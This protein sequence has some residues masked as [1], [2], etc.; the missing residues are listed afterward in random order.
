MGS[1]LNNICMYV[2]MYMLRIFNNHLCNS[3][4]WSCLFFQITQLFPGIH[5][6]MTFINFIIRYKWVFIS[7]QK[8]LFAG[9]LLTYILASPPP[10][11]PVLPPPP[12]P[13]KGF[14][15][16]VKVPFCLKMSENHA[17]ITGNQV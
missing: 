12:P 14:G 2:C 10:P 17:E 1:E 11:A 15:P 9:P 3:T 16:L 6:F 13:L 7:N 8:L 5:Q 4:K